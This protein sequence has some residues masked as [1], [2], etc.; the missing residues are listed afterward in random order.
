MK[1]QIY[2]YTTED[3]QDFANMVK[4]GILGELWNNGNISGYDNEEDLVLDHVVLI[5]RKGLLGM[6]I[7]KI[8]PTDKDSFEIRFAKLRR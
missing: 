7:E 2:Q 4:D 6:M 3:I 5:K 1:M 8:M